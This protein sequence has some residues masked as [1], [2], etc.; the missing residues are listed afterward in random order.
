VLLQEV[1][2]KEKEEKENDEKEG[3]ENAKFLFISPQSDIRLSE[4]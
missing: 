1:E 4:P 2:E 3:S